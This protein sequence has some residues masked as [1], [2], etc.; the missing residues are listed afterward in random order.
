MRPM[1]HSTTTKPWS[2]RSANNTPCVLSE[3]DCAQ[4]SRVRT[5]CWPRPKFQ[6]AH[7]P[8]EAPT[9]HIRAG[10]MSLDVGL[11]LTHALRRWQDSNICAASETNTHV[12]GGWGPWPR[13]GRIQGFINY[14]FSL[15]PLTLPTTK[16]PTVVVRSRCIASLDRILL[17]A[18][19]ALAQPAAIRPAWTVLL[20]LLPILQAEF[21]IMQRQTH[22]LRDRAA[23]M[24]DDSRPF[25]AAIARVK[26]SLARHSCGWQQLPANALSATIPSCQVRVLASTL[27]HCGIPW[28]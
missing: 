24:L 18:G 15:S 10:A 27:L 6:Q 12:G 5:E 21:G 3:R 4:H 8:P 25:P 22:S 23:S 1:R 2:E 7:A 14:P 17:Y 20:A 28:D 9:D 26:H 13:N 11:S 16:T 19:P